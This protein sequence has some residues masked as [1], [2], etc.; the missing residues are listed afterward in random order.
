MK[1]NRKKDESKKRNFAVWVEKF[2]WVLCLAV[3][4]T[5][6][7]LVVNKGLSL[8]SA[9]ILIISLALVGLCI[10]NRKKL[11]SYFLKHK[12]IMRCIGVILILLGITLRL[13]FLFAQGS[14]HPNQT[15]SDTGVHWYGAQQLVDNGQFDKE[16]GDYETVY[17]YLFSY[18]GSLA[19]LMGIFG[20][21]FLSVIMLNLSFDLIAA[22]GLFILFWK[23][24]KSKDAGLF[25]V[26]VWLI[27]P[28][29]ILFCGLSLAI[30]IVNALMILATLAT[31]LVYSNMGNTKRIILY[32]ILLGLIIAIGNAYRP[33]FIIFG[34]A[35]FVY[36]IICLLGKRLT[37]RNG[38]LSIAATFLTIVLVGLLPSKIHQSVN[39]YYH[40]EKSQAGWSIFVGAHYET[41]GKWSSDDRDFFFGPVL[42]DQAEGDVN[43]AYSIIIQHAIKRYGK[44]ALDGKLITH[45]LNK[46]SLTFGDVRNSYYD[47]P[48]AYNISKESRIYNFAQDWSL[49]FYYLTLG[50]FFAF[51]FKGANKFLRNKK[52]LPENGFSLIMIIAFVGFFFAMLMVESM[53]R[54]S[55]P[56]IALMV[57]F[58]IEYLIEISRK[59]TP[60]P[61]RP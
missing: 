57:V 35:L 61:S 43:K 6:T 41:S 25:A 42:I 37:F 4:S 18:T 50:L 3:V 44:I 20:K 13:A 55:L 30:V 26:V 34:I 53:N 59:D 29:E 46:T 45:F 56:F 32:S 19:V 15:L 1:K 22:F 28:F 12:K 33:F 14:Y 8:S 23:W 40:G 24:K 47:I 2:F 9:S 49:I 11:F 16:V 38:V 10:K 31:Y 27:N 39:P 52:A 60:R 36:Y 54:Y 21:G 58:A 17:P 7:I 51:L 48:Y 5:I